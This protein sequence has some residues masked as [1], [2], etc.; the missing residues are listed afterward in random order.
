MNSNYLKRN[1]ESMQKQSA[2]PVLPIGFQGIEIERFIKIF[3]LERQNSKVNYCVVAAYPNSGVGFLLVNYDNPSALREKDALLKE[4]SDAPV[5][6]VSRGPLNNPPAYHIRGMLM[7]ERVLSVLDRI[8]IQVPLPVVTQTPTE[9]TP[10]EPPKLLTKVLETKPTVV[11]VK[12]LAE[13]TPNVVPT[14]TS[15]APT[16]GLER[17]NSHSQV[18]SATDETVPAQPVLE[19]KPE[20]PQAIE[21]E[22]PPAVA[23]TASEVAEGYRA[24]VVDDSPAIQK[25]IEINLATLEQIGAIDFADSGES[26][27]EKAYS[28]HYDLIFLD[29]MMPGI[30]GYE[31]CSRIRKNPD[32]KR[33]PII[34]VSGKTSPMDEVKGIMAGAT[35]Y[36]TK[37][38]Q[39]DQF[40]K[41]GVRVLTWLAAQKNRYAWTVKTA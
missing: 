4:N 25:S 6:A 14:S 7:A 22:I 36:L 15:E 1:T 19:A 30:D 29:I 26:A 12:P 24:L 10:D 20:I 3:Q 23:E 21:T 35:T 8:P 40:Q 32:Y 16:V 13:A 33:T 2:Q 37:P 39:Q 5:I 27:I 18:S 41:L 38:V 17:Q 31:T 34:M 9:K 28:V 11:P